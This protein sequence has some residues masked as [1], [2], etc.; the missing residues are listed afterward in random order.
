MG[1]EPIASAAELFAASET[2]VETAQRLQAEEALRATFEQAAV[3]MAHLALDGSFMRVNRALCGILGYTERQLL[4]RHLRDLAH[5]EDVERACAAFVR[6]VAGEGTSY[7]L[8]TRY[9]RS[10]GGVIWADLSV[11]LVT[12]ERG[13][14]RYAIL[15]AEDVTAR[16]R[17]LEALGDS[18]RRLKLALEAGGLGSWQI[19]L[20]TGRIEACGRCR[21]LLGLTAAAEISLATIHAL[22]HPED[23]ARRKRALKEALDTGEYDCEYRILDAEGDVRWLAARGQVVRD[24]EQRPVRLVGVLFDATDR[25]RNEEELRRLNVALTRRVRQ[26]TRQLE[27]EVEERTRAQRAERASEARYAAVF[28]HTTAGIILL[29]VAADGRFVYEAVNPTHERFTGMKAA[30]FV[31][32]T[33]YDLFPRALA[34]RLIGYYRRACDSGEPLSYEETF[35]YRV[36]ARVLQATAVPIRD[37]DGAV[38]KL[39]ISTHDM[40]A[41]K[42]AEE[43]LRQGQKMEAIGQ[44][45]GGVAH[46]FNN[47]LTAVIGNL[48][49]LARQLPGAAQAR[50][51]DSAVRAAERGARLTQQL[52]AFARKQ[53][54]EPKPV[55]LNRLIEDMRDM[56]V[57][58][59]GAT[60]RIETRPGE[61]IWPAM[62]DAN[63]IE[64]VLLNLA[65]N[66]R[67]AMP[68]GGVIT[69][70]SAM[71]SVAP[72]ERGPAELAPGDYV[73][74]SVAD[75]G[76]GMSEEIRAKVFEPFFTTKEVG[77]GSGLGLSQVYGIARQLGGGVE[78]DSAPGA[79]TVVRVYLPRAEGVA[80]RSED[81]RTAA[82]PVAHN[83]AR[84]LVVDDDA[85][86]REFVAACL[87]GFGYDVVE[88]ADGPAALGLVARE[89]LDLLLVDFAMPEM[90]GAELVRRARRERPGLKAM[91]MTGYAEVAPLEGEIDGI[92]VLRKPFRLGDLAARLGTVL[93]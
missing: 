80:A 40:T 67:D 41:R 46:D 72:G 88:A 68:A 78:I 74:L 1:V 45:T 51:I 10:D 24:A 61:S 20:V 37:A 33:S 54:L 13:A 60:V 76:A 49:L 44:L 50:L 27:G 32:L 84:I 92:A 85:Q 4:Q 69:I 63:Q 26:R 73:V 29:R 35:P 7:T 39:L 36:G 79:G 64:L 5:A 42:A 8:E 83:S 82:E 6:L 25:K 11:S 66:A 30:D 89:K 87:S 21:A 91:F 2:F 22:A 52:L 34:E 31:G 38:A 77:M 81:A 23:R 58:T 57:S 3:G 15:V 62:L 86:V 12:D 9:R 28:Q 43:T 56:L 93:G 59:I 48:E 18:E 17:V 75:T 90:N 47:L 16:K 53:R 19:D 55:D 14:P 71:R 65:I 70:G